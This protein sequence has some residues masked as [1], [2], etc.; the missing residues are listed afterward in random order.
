MV[1][2]QI[3]EEATDKLVAAYEKLIPQ[4]SQSSRPPTK[5]DLERM[6]NSDITTVL[7]ATNKDDQIVGTMTLVLFRIP[8]GLRAWIEDVI[9]DSE[10]QGKGIGKKLNQKALTIAEKAGAKTVELTSRPSR[11]AANRLYQNLGFEKRETNIY[12]FTFD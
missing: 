6:I 4:L 5:Q 8:T 10:S 1:K 9:V 7:I 11:E 3:A 12:R 2:I